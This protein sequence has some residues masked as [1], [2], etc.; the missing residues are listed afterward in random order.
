M[1]A[2]TSLE[3]AKQGSQKSEKSLRDL[4]LHLLR[5]QDEERRQIG[6]EIHDSLGSTF[7]YL[8]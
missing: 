8:K 3:E 2:Q 6:R 5:K 1:L 7:R 4:S